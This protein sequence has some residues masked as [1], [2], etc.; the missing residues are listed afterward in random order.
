MCGSASWEL[1]GGWGSGAAHPWFAKLDWNRLAVR[2]LKAPYVPTIKSPTDG[3]NFF[4]YTEEPDPPSD[5]D[6][7]LVLEE[8]F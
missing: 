8:L 1:I 4:K 5:P 7:E 6:S 2:R 3:S